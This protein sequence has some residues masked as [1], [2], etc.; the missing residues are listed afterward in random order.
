MIL[1]VIISLYWASVSVPQEMRGAHVLLFGRIHLPSVSCCP[2]ALHNLPTSYCKFNRRRRTE[3][4]K[5]W[6]YAPILLVDL[7]CRSALLLLEF[8]A[9][10]LCWVSGCYTPIL[11]LILLFWILK[12]NRLPF[13]PSFSLVCYLQSQIIFTGSFTIWHILL[14]CQLQ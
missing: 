8:Y 11:T 7:L 3:L 10:R 1:K 13:S 5:Y 14:A 2:F 4:G 6:S 9:Y 12:P